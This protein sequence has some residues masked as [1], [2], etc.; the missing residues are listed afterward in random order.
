MQNN[1]F[2]SAI[3]SRAG[4]PLV[5]GRYADA[6]AYCESLFEGES[7]FEFSFAYADMQERFVELDRF[8]WESKHL[9]RF[10]NEYIGNTVI[11][12]TEW[13]SH[14]YALNEYF[15]AFL[16]YLKSK[17]ATLTV[18][19]ILTDACEPELIGRLKEVFDVRPVILTSTM[20]QN[21]TKIKIG[22]AP[23]G[24]REKDV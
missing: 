20:N 12:L 9:A 15:D 16:Y 24:G 1:A 11:D 7:Y 19:F 10:R 8:V 21:H 18:C 23:Q 13:N 2:S 22:F 3:A 17:E 4:V 6:L 5:Q 14:A